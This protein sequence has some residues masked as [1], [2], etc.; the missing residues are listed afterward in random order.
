MNLN[1]KLT[2]ESF[3]N[4]YVILTALVSFL[5]FII[6]C[7]SSKEGDRISKTDIVK[8]VSSI[9]I[10][11]EAY[12]NKL[13]AVEKYFLTSKYSNC[14]N[15]LLHNADLNDIHKS[16][17]RTKFIAGYCER[18]FVLSAPTLNDATERNNLLHRIGHAA[19]SIVGPLVSEEIMAKNLELRTQLQ[20]D[21]I[22]LMRKKIHEK[23]FIN[24]IS[25]DESKRKKDQCSSG[26]IDSLTLSRAKK[27]AELQ[28]RIQEKDLYIALKEREFIA[29]E[30]DNRKIVNS[31]ITDIGKQLNQFITISSEENLLDFLSFINTI[32]GIK[33]LITA[34]AIS[35]VNRHLGSGEHLK[36][37]YEGNVEGLLDLVALQTL[38]KWRYKDKAIEFYPN[39][40][41]VPY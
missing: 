36:I 2:G 34:E 33:V 12:S 20:D 6:T 27:V 37:N 28:Y 23:M 26:D 39:E 16:F 22:N 32:T 4:K 24:Q 19:F 5:V 7:L 31:N 30:L 15:D 14:T 38:S 17:E 21:D 41:F 40:E 13:S 3:V 11:M 1:K 8:E 25:C 35:Y 18:Y 9:A 10:G 29:Q